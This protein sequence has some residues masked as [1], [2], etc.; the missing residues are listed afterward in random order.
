MVNGN[1]LHCVGFFEVW[2]FP[3][4]Y[5][6]E[7][8]CNTVESLWE[9]VESHSAGS[10][11]AFDLDEVNSQCETDTLRAQLNHNLAS[12]FLKMQ[13]ILHV[14]D[15]ASQEIVEHLTQIFSLSQLILKH[16]IREVRVMTS[17]SVI[18]FKMR[19]SVLLLYCYELSQDR[20]QKQLFIKMF[21]E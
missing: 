13:S 21:T 5:Y 2:D 1:E 12:L 9:P 4:C 19:L 15:M 10:E 6:P 8:G 11:D 18:H 7:P 17:L 16:Y 3:D 14:L 20:Q